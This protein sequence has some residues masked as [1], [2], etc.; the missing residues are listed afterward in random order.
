MA[1]RT[2]DIQQDITDTHKNIADTRLAMTE[3]LEMLEQRVRETVEG[4]Q[5]SAGDMVE[6]VKETVDTTVETM[7]QTVEGAQSSVE[8]IVENVTRTVEETVATVKRTFDLHYQV[9]QHPWLLVGG[10]LLVGYLLGSRGSSNTSAVVSP[11]TDSRLSPVS[12]TAVSSHEASARPQPQPR[13]GSGIRERFKDEIAIIEG[14]VIGAVISTVRDMVKQALLPPPPQHT[15]ALPMR[16][17]QPSESSAPPPASLARASVNEPT[18]S[19]SLPVSTRQS[20]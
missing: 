11:T 18:S 10:S 6:N 2:D 19:R 7:R 20:A 4:A 8:D 5:S 15:S 9:D 16:D 14:A 12:T 17:G 1:H 13:M 3:K